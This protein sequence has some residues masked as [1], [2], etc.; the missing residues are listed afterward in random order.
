M[1]D[2]TASVSA[3]ELMA[4]ASQHLDNKQHIKVHTEGNQVSWCVDRFRTVKQI[5]TLGR[6]GKRQAEDFKYGLT[7]LAQRDARLHPN[8]VSNR[9]AEEVI[10]F[11]N[12]RIAAS[13][14]AE[15]IK[16][17]STSSTG[18]YATKVLNSP[19]WQKVA[20]VPPRPVILPGASQAAAQ[21]KQATLDALDQA[22]DAWDEH[23]GVAMGETICTRILNAYENDWTT[24]DFESAALTSLPP[25][26][27]LVALEELHLDDNELRSLDSLPRLP[28]LRKLTLNNNPLSALPSD[29]LERLPKLQHLDLSGT[30]ISAV[31]VPPEKLDLTITFNP[32]PEEQRKADKREQLVAQL[33]NWRSTTDSPKS[34]EV[35]ERIL[36][37]YDTDQASLDLSGLQLTSVPPLGELQALE[38]LNLSGNEIVRPHFDVKLAKLQHL[39][40]ASNPIKGLPDDFCDN[41]PELQDVKLSQTPFTKPPDN[42][43]WPT[44]LSVQI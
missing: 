13:T 27:P 43:A 40:L 3:T 36:Q 28:N 33:N 7:V 8:G 18:S 23:A 30:D 5:L 4:V 34:P 32:R 16:R 42:V 35:I 2:Y 14:F 31:N 39:S 12:N 24:L 10:K 15:Q 25:L 6:Y 1:R 37:A 44:M 21:E 38:T 29:L 41:L 19:V 17:I 9:Q 20:Q 26:H 11:A 22:L